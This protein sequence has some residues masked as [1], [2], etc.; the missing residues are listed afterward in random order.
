MAD[1]EWTEVACHVADVIRHSEHTTVYASHTDIGG[2]HGAPEIYT[3]WGIK[4]DDAERPVLREWRYLPYYEGEPD[5]KPCLHL[6]PTRAWTPAEEN[7]HG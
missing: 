3:E 1:P 4:D 6:V 2:E 7:E 5:R